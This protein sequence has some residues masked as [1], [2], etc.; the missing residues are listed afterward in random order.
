LGRVRRWIEGILAQ[1]V[2]AQAAS[3]TRPFVVNSLRLRDQF[4]DEV[5]R[6][7]ERLKAP[8]RAALAEVPTADPARDTEAIYQ[9]AM[10]RMHSF[11][12]QGERPA[13]R[14]VEHIVEFA[15]R[16]LRSDSL[17]GSER[18]HGA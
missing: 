15:I 3:S 2:D 11:V 6:S 4:R 16:G 10:G 18:T 8:L 13:R 9:L 5:Q 7:D 17:S 12:L 1:A 14:D